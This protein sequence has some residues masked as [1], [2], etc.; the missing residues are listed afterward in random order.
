MKIT[1][2]IPD[3]SLRNAVE[4]Q[5]GIALSA[6][7]RETIDKD[8]KEIISKSLTRIDWYGMAER[9]AQKLLEDHIENAVTNVLGNKYNRAETVRRLVQEAALQA[10][11]GS[12]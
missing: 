10:I 1:I 7:T 5:V 2:E 8:A 12:K 11:K 9:A 6:L 3:E 4:A